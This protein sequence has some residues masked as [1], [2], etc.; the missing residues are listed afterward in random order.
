MTS[1]SD[2]NAAHE[3]VWCARSKSH[4]GILAR[5]LFCV[6]RRQDLHGRLE[7]C[8]WLP[9]FLVRNLN[10]LV[11]QHRLL[12]LRLLIGIESKLSVKGVDLVL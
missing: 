1:C 3:V 7:V 11:L 10:V 9:L 6:E 12:S 2:L 4:V 5:V 8:G